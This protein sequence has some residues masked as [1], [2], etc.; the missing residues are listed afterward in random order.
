MAHPS[1]MTTRGASSSGGL[2]YQLG[3]PSLGLDLGS[4]RLL[5][6]GQT[7]APGE[8]VGPA[9][10]AHR[11]GLGLLSRLLLGVESGAELGRGRVGPPRAD[12]LQLNRGRHIDSP[13]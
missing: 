1:T 13:R 7:L 8:V 5:L 11:R 12:R 9:A 2:D 6:R 4:D 10:I 3:Q